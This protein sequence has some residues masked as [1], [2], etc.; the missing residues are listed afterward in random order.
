MTSLSTRCG[1]FGTRLQMAPVKSLSAL[2]EAKASYRKLTKSVFGHSDDEPEEL[3]PHILEAGGATD[4]VECSILAS[5]IESLEEVFEEFKAMDFEEH[6]LELVYT[7]NE[8]RRDD[9]TQNIKVLKLGVLVSVTNG[10]T[11]LATVNLTL[12]RYDMLQRHLQ[13]VEEFQEGNY[14]QANNWMRSNCTLNSGTPMKRRFAF[15][16]ST[17]TVPH[18]TTTLWW[19]ATAKEM[20]EAG[21]RQLPEGAI[22]LKDPASRETPAH[23]RRRSITRDSS[24][25]AHTNVFQ[26]VRNNISQ[27]REEQ[28]ALMVN[29]VWTELKPNGS[30][31]PGR[32]ASLDRTVPDN[33]TVMGKDDLIRILEYN[34]PDRN[35]N[36]GTAEQKEV[37]R[38]AY[39]LRTQKVRLFKD[40]AGDLTAVQDF[41]IVYITGPDYEQTLVRESAPYGIPVG[42]RKTTLPLDMAAGMLIRT[43]LPQF[44]QQDV[45][46]VQKVD[47][48]TDGAFIVRV[49]EDTAGLIPRAKRFFNI[50]ATVKREADAFAL[51]RAALTVGDR[52]PGR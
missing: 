48:T 42:P 15:K 40:P 29:S 17:L 23:M 41:V 46:E 16:M 1:Q 6:G 43:D 52:C 27:C 25:S 11:I 50:Q 12:R 36:K 13:I 28:E 37:E 24:V 30:E 47:P 33:S 26:W 19:W 8:F 44:L 22:V 10:H 14:L 9:D 2:L 45:F 34:F 3:V 21:L 18:G 38:L 5:S 7:E 39:D 4:L 32:H 20:E 31:L 49:P 51:C 35:W